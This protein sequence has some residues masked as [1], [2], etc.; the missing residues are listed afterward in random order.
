MQAMYKAWQYLHF[1]HVDCCNK[2]KPSYSDVTEIDDTC[3]YSHNEDWL[4]YEGSQGAIGAMHISNKRRNL[5][6][7]NAK[8][9]IHISGT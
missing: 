4:N 8:R 7:S 3:C 5:S 2:D 1:N 6:V 9:R